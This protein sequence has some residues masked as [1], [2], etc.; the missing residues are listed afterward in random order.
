VCKWENVFVREKERERERDRSS[1]LKV[2][3]ETS[4]N[5]VTS[6]TYPDSC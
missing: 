6:S 5:R 1:V 3:K 2:K 4:K